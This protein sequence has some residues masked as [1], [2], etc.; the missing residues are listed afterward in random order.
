MGYLTSNYNQYSYLLYRYF[1]LDLMLDLKNIQSTTKHLNRIVRWR[2][3]QFPESVKSES[4]PGLDLEPPLL[5]TFRSYRC[6]LSSFLNL[7]D[8][9][10]IIFPKASGQGVTETS[11]CRNSNCCKA[12]GLCTKASFLRPCWQ[13][14]CSCWP[15][16]QIC[17]HTCCW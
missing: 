8:C 3:L 6:S 16:Q 1:D 4:P 7:W 9:W 15:A 13:A 11:G 12:T 17:W 14:T 5:A 10:T 2:I